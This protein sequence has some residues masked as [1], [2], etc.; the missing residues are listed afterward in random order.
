MLLL[1]GEDDEPYLHGVIYRVMPPMKR[2]MPMEALSGGEKTVASLALIFALHHFKPSPFFVLD[3]I[4]AA[5]DNIN[6]QR[7]A[8]Y[9]RARATRDHLQVLVISLKETFYSKANSLIGV[10]RDVDTKSSANLTLDLTKYD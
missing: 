9:V 1:E 7:V 2:Y 8:N 3:E 4:D 6:V 10:Y 5:L